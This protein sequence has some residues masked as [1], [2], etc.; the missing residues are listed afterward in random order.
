MNQNLKLLFLI[1]KIISSY[2]LTEYCDLRCIHQENIVCKRQNQNCS[3]AHRCGSNKK[4]GMTDDDRKRA[5]DYHNSLRNYVASGG[6]ERNSE[7]PSSNM[8]LLSYSLE[9]EY[10]AQCQCNSCEKNHEA[11][12]I[13]PKFWAVAQNFYFNNTGVFDVNTAIKFWYEEINNNKKRKLV[14]VQKQTKN[15]AQLLWARTTH[16]GC[17]KTEYYNGYFFVCCN[18]AIR[19]RKMIDASSYKI[20]NPCSRCGKIFQCSRVY[21]NL[22]TNEK[23]DGQDYTFYTDRSFREP[24]F[25]FKGGGVFEP[26]KYTTVRSGQEKTFVFTESLILIYC[27]SFSIGGIT[28][29]F[30]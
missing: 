14:R 29:R 18:Y 10:S 19:G 27:A 20:G 22:C 21:H 26:F 17:G 25:P 5:L 30:L 4:S 12:R 3:I 16:I 28:P 23:D 15:I 13:T 7:T 9:L 24:N 8:L 6:E 11:C 1:F 2:N